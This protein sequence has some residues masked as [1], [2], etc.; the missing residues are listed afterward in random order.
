MNLATHTQ[1]PFLLRNLVPYG[2]QSLERSS[3]LQKKVS[4]DCI[5]IFGTSLLTPVHSREVTTSS[6]ENGRNAAFLWGQLFFIALQFSRRRRNLVTVGFPRINGTVLKDTV[7]QVSSMQTFSWERVSAQQN[8][9]K[10]THNPLQCPKQLSQALVTKRC[11]TGFHW[12]S[13][14]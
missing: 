13:T 14:T 3:T 2:T 4:K 10:T 1:L 6:Q 9:I 12:V 7:L 8:P 11:V 5:A